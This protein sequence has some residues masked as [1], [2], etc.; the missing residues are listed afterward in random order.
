MFK[1][2]ACV[3]LTLAVVLLCFAGCKKEETAAK[4]DF[5]EKGDYTKL[6]GYY[7]ALQYDI[8]SSRDIVVEKDYFVFL[9]EECTKL[10]GTMIVSFN[11]DG[12]FE[13]YEAAIGIL[14]VEELINYYQTESSG[15][16][17]KMCFSDNDKLSSVEWENIYGD[18]VTGEGT[19]TSGNIECHS[20]GNYKT[21]FE[22]EYTFSPDKKYLSATTEREY[23]SNG[24]LLSEKTVK[25][26]ENGKVLGS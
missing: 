6:D 2:F 9:D 11:D 20:N 15:L 25:Y 24:G 12:V 8:K 4:L 10:V 17:T 21:S 13:K 1:K 5:G 26:D 22:E 3:I 16:Y 14:R 7:L 23:G 19:I 18:P